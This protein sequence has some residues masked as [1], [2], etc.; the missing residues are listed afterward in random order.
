M[1]RRP[2][3]AP[4]PSGFGGLTALLAHAVF[5]KVV[6]SRG[7]APRHQ[8]WKT[9]MHLSTSAPEKWPPVREVRPPLRFFKPALI[10]LSYLAK[11]AGA[12]VAP[13]EDGV[14][15]HRESHSPC[16]KWSPRQW[17]QLHCPV[18]KTGD[19]CS[20]STWG[21][22][23]HPDLDSHQDKAGNNRLCY[24]DTTWIKSASAQ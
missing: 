3:A 11:V 7:I 8:V 6:G 24:F 13:A 14:W 20:W 18:S 12:G 23:W 16:R 22:N 5:G 1:A 21:K 19:S 9:C 17:L 15:A 2:G 10:D 4:G